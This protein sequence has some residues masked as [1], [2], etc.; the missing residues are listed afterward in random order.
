MNPISSDIR[1]NI[2]ALLQQGFSIRQVSKK[3]GVT[4]S[5]IQNVR[6]GLVQNIILP[7]AGRPSKL[8]PQNKRFCTR[9]ITAGR[10]DTV[11]E[12]TKLLETEMNVHVNEQTVRRALQEAGLKA[13]E[14]EKRLKLSP[15][16]IK[17][18][19]AFAKR[20][21]DWTITD[22]KRIIWSDE[23]KISRFCSDGRS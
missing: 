21:K 2:I 20:H 13:M 7:N 15:K 1:S 9:A 17:A 3:C 23:T 11:K 14:K 5:T 22:W 4:K 8:S 16:N 19:L 10:L 6:R 12:V 18:R